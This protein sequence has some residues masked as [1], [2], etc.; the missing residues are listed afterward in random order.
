MLT[1]M[2]SVLQDKVIIG[3]NIDYYKLSLQK[4]E[5]AK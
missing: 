2:P 4:N 5:D 1:G 3:Y